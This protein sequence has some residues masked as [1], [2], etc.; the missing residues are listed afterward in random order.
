[1][2]DVL[3][4]GGTIVDG[5]GA[6][7]RPAD[8]R[9]RDGVI[10]DVAPSLRP[11][12][13][14]VIDASHAYVIPGIIDTHTH[15]DGAMWWS[16]DLDPLPAYG[17]TTAVFGNCGNSI[18]P[19]RGPQRDE[20]VDLLCFL[21]DL[22]VEAFRRCIPWSWE[23]WP[24]YMKAIGAQPT[25]LNLLGYFG[26]VSVR[27]FVMGEAAWER[28]ATT[29]EIAAMCELLD[30][31]LRYGALGLSVNHFD[32]DRTLRLVPGFYATDEEFT[33]LFAVVARYPGRTVQLV[34]RFN[35]PDHYLSDNERFARLCKQA[36]VRAQWP[37]V[38]T[39]VLERAKR[40]PLWALQHQVNAEGGDFWS[41][42]AH[43]PLEPFFG[44]EKSIVFQRVPAWNELVNGP[45]DEKMAALADPAW[46]ARARYEWDNRPH[47]AT[48]RVDRPHSLIFAISET[49]A[50][51]LG[52]SLA[53]HASALGVHVSD[54][55]A[56]WLLHNGI[57]SSLVGTPDR[58]E[59]DDVVTLLREPRTISNV[60][61][62]GAHLQL[63]C[64][65]GQ[66][67]YMLT[68]Y[69][70]DT[71]QLRIEE[72]VHALTGRTADFFGLTDRGHI[73]PGKIGD[74]AVFAMDEIE[75]RQEIRYH[76]VP[77]GTWRFSRPP[78][79]FR[80]TVVRGTPTWLHGESTGEH[81]GKVTSRYY[82]A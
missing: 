42:V 56:E 32:K 51:P 11:Q 34:T 20:V 26:H 74:L 79:G 40:D 38:P 59:E 76:D 47:V 50:G 62:S 54:A 57:G 27:S 41:T 33:A 1:M 14:L 43:K 77:F 64:G 22:P 82:T 52:I 15:L 10:V 78:S 60:N 4:R 71:G 81:P 44:F 8:V 13:E 48:S 73:A 16:P 21:E 31:A 18:A 25:T 12:G 17:T 72:G 2:G 9:V 30:E 70:R 6:S 23:R 55:L 63:F 80:A 65:A 5:S 67:V 24:D 35:D 37:G 45:A 58:L 19:T 36:G 49:G 53:D 3:V 69:V 61:D 39:D 28:A 68:H 7:P 75:M 66:D 29:T 46:R